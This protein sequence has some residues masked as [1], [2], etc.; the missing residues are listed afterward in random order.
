MLVGSTRGDLIPHLCVLFHLTPIFFECD[1]SSLGIP[2]LIFDLDR[3]SHNDKLHILVSVALS[4]HIAPLLSRVGSFLSPF[5]YLRGAEPQ[6]LVRIHGLHCDHHCEIVGEFRVGSEDQS[7]RTSLNLT[8]WYGGTHW[9]GPFQPIPPH[10]LHSDWRPGVWGSSGSEQLPLGS[11]QEPGPEPTGPLSLA[12]WRC[13][14]L[15]MVASR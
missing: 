9:V 3:F 11:R 12:I 8:Q 4:I 2:Y 6:R 14:L 13:G 10:C 7:G 1:I 5:S 15:P